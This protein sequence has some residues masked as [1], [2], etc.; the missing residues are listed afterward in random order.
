MKLSTWMW[1][2]TPLLGWE[3]YIEARARRMSFERPVLA[4]SRDDVR[5]YERGRSLLISA[6]LNFE[7]G[8]RDI[9]I[10]GAVRWDDGSS[11]TSDERERVM[12]TLVTDLKRRRSTFRVC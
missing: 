3:R 6:E 9:T 8:G 11:V 1:L 2:T 10:T 12:N 4:W 5:Y 7:H